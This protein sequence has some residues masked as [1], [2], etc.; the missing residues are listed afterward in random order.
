[1]SFECVDWISKS[2]GYVLRVPNL[3]RVGPGGG[4]TEEEDEKRNA[5]EAEEEAGLW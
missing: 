1:M 3:V 4:G 2:A 5:E